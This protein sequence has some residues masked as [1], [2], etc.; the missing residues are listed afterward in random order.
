MSEHWIKVTEF[1]PRRI[2][3]GR[4][5]VQ[6]FS[7]RLMDF[8]EWI[9]VH[10][11]RR[12]YVGSRAEFLKAFLPVHA[13]PPF[14][15]GIPIG[16]LLQTMGARDALYVGRMAPTSRLAK[17]SA[18]DRAGEMYGRAV[19]RGLLGKLVLWE[20][21]V[22]GG[23][24]GLFK[25]P[26]PPAAAPEPVTK[27]PPLQL[28]PDEMARWPDQVREDNDSFDWASPPKSVPVDH[29]SMPGVGADSDF[30]PFDLPAGDDA[31]V[32]PADDEIHGAAPHQPPHD[33]APSPGVLAPE[34]DAPAFPE[35]DPAK[36]PE[37]DRWVNAVLEDHDAGEPLVFQSNYVLAISIDLDKSTSVGA[38]GA[39]PASHLT[40]DP[41]AEIKLTVTL[42]SSD[43]DISEPQR[44]LTISKEGLSIGKA[45]FDIRPKMTSGSA[46]LTAVIHRENNF[47]QQLD[48]AF[49]V[50]KK[51]P[52]GMAVTSVGRPVEVAQSLLRR[53]IGLSIQPSPLGGYDCMTWGATA[54]FAHLPISAGEL[55]QGIENVRRALLGVVMA[56]DAN[57]GSPFQ[58]GIAIDPGISARGLRVIAKAGYL[59]FRS[60]F[61]HPAADAQCQS[62]GTYLVNEVTKADEGFTLQVLA[63]DFPVPWSLLYLTDA[64]E[65]NAVQWKGFLGAKLIVEQIPLCN[66]CNRRDTRIPGIPDGLAVSLNFNSDI[67]VQFSGGLVAVQQAYW[68]GVT[69][70][71]PRI[72]S[73]ART[74][75]ADLINSLKDGALSDQII[76]FY[77][78]A[79]SLGLGAGGGP[80]QS[81][82]IMSGPEQVTLDD[83]NL[84]APAQQ[85]LRGA[86]L[87]FINACESGELSPLFYNGFVPYFLSKGARGVIGTECKVPALFA[88][89]WAK[90]FFDKFLR[91]SPIGET[92]R[93]LRNEFF[94]EGGNPLG[95]LY[96]VHC[97]ADTQI[98]PLP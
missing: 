37:G 13:S 46:R 83:L 88:S 68:R 64:W 77:C 82:L 96:G 2:I 8:G 81:R 52:E 50:G 25:K 47:V 48:I 94:D 40:R 15:D 36:E 72:R 44:P 60:L 16:E 85:K 5:R 59:L 53:D 78:H 17:T 21:S 91:G 19:S 35:L 6:E 69:E 84:D 29:P 95:L 58:Q 3:D 39:A 42:S 80:G 22:R 7:A 1:D 76:Y 41:D 38:V 11:E 32:L 9:V 62:L 10:D 97:N 75:K 43:F 66:D 87:V 86:P 28:P 71:S 93:D 27:Y 67:D 89:E 14:D 51:T 74:S 34:A 56:K 33:D 49:E 90:R 54:S 31:I 12:W 45:R 92:V 26:P 79:E 55:A 57:G 61:F 4:M 73:V 18:T 70:G 63:R 24:P 30:L 98:D 20:R 65:E 23:K